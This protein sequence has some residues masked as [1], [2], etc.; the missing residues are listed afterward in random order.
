MTI[1]TFGDSH[2][3]HPWD[4]IIINEEKI[5]IHILRPPN[6][7]MTCAGFGYNKLEYLNIKNYDVEDNDVVCFCFGETDCRFHIDKR[8]EI[9]KDF[10]NEI[11]ENYFEAIKLNI[12]QLNNLTVIVLSVPP[13]LRFTP[14]AADFPILGEDT[15]RKKY[16]EYFNFIIKG[17]CEEYNYH[18][19][20]VY[21]LYS[22]QDGYLN[23]EYA[24]NYCHIMDPIFM[25]EELI[26]ILKNEL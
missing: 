12:E 25:E 20:D 1:H 6:R 9:Y 24:D 22:N 8:K 21:N 7:P 15:D 4:R 2:A 18:N 23:P 3:N 16:S 14:A 5:N 26:K 11:V 17:K 13:V 19:L 10:I